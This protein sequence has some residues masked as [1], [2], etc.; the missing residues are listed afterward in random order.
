[1][2]VAGLTKQ[3]HRSA[4]LPVFRM[5]WCSRADP[6]M[7]SPSRTPDEGPVQPRA[8]YPAGRVQRAPGAES[9]D[10]LR[11]HTWAVLGC[12]GDIPARRRVAGHEL[13]LHGAPKVLV[14]ERERADRQGD[15]VD[16][17]YYSLET[18]SLLLA[19]KAR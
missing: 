12:F 10:G 19:L 8:G 6:E 5:N 16:R 13:Y 9:G 15:F 1:M 2:Y 4:P 18:V 14:G 11:G 17:G 3:L 7:Q